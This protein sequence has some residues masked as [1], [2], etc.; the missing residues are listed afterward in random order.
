MKITAAAWN[1]Q[2]GLAIPHR[3][4]SLVEGIKQLDSDVVMLT[5]AYW[6]GNPLHELDF[7]LVEE[8]QDAFTNEGYT[9]QKIWYEDASDPY[10]DRLMLGLGRIGLEMTSVNLDG[11]NAMKLMLHDPASSMQSGLQ[12]FGVHLDDR[13]E[14]RRVAQAYSIAAEISD[15]S[16]TVVIGDF[17]SLDNIT[18]SA[19][20]IKT[21]LGK[22]QNA[23][24]ESRRISDRIHAVASKL[25]DMAAGTTLDVLREAGLHDASAKHTATFPS[26]LPV[27]ALDRCMVTSDVQASLQRQ[28]HR[29]GSDHRAV[30]VSVEF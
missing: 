10:P 2:E 5:D 22:L 21:T 13:S 16:P 15:A 23:H 17:N 18:L 14:A 3:S 11:R 19:Q 26:R 4:Q 6:P 29:P 8:A 30:K 9:V 20:L 27:L 12:I 25:G 24:H 1:I 7:S 28:P